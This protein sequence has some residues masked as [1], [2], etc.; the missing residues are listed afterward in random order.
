MEDFQDP[1]LTETQL[2]D[3]RFPRRN[4]VS[5]NGACLPSR[6]HAESCRRNIPELLPHANSGQGK[7]R[8]IQI[9]LCPAK[10]RQLYGEHV[11][12]YDEY[13]SGWVDVSEDER[14]VGCWMVG[15]SHAV[16]VWVYLL[17]E[18]E[19]DGQEHGQRILVVSRCA[20]GIVH[21]HGLNAVVSRFQREQEAAPD[22]NERAYRAFPPTQD[23]TRAQNL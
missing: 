5:C 13:V 4:T 8:R 1:Y 16:C 7:Q 9:Y 22:A 14:V 21:Q 2:R 11:A 20:M 6:Q 23:A 17:G 19:W 18:E 12:G 15:E 10:P 3:A